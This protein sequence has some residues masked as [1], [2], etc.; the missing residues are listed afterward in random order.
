MTFRMTAY[1]LFAVLLLAGGVQAIL[2]PDAIY[3]APQIRAE[4]ARREQLREEGKK[5][6]DIFV[7][8]QY[9]KV[10][11][12]MDKPPWLRIGMQADGELA[13]ADRALVART[14]NVQKGNNRFFISVVLLILIGGVVGWIRYATRELDE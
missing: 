14:G 12:D 1:S 10:R 7:I 9:E 8:Q 5:K 2:P 6:R 11:A 13:V 3:R 4:Y